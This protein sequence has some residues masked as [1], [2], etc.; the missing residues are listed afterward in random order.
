[1]RI[2]LLLGMTLAVSACTFDPYVDTGDA[3]QAGSWR[4]EK[5]IDRVTSA[6]IESAMLTAPSSHSSELFPMR[7]TMQLACFNKKPLVR[8][9]FEVKVGTTHSNEF[10]YRFDDRPCHQITAGFLGNDKVAVIENGADVA[11]FLSEMAT[12]KKLYVRIRSLGFGRTTVDF[13]VAEAAAAI[14]ATTAH[15]PPAIEE[16]KPKRKPR[17]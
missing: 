3:T 6:P 1:M 13:N 2:V 12:A 4:I 9:A 15:C 5:Q 14:A 17:R 10:G 16:P 7:A 8:F 11:Q